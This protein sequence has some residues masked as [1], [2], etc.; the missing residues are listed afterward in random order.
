MQLCGTNGGDVSLTKYSLAQ[1]MAAAC[2]SLLQVVPQLP[3]E[4]LLPW[5][6]KAQECE[7]SIAI[8]SVE[9]YTMIYNVQIANPEPDETS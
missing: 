9:A 2:I 7:S 4:E 5:Q 6:Y 8:R 3:Q 1:L